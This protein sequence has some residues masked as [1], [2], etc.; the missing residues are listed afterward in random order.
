MPKEYGLTCAEYVALLK[1]EVDN[2]AAFWFDGRRQDPKNF[3]ERMGPGDWAEQFIAFKPREKDG[4][5]S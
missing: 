4:R 5:V 1:Q 3:P 2:F